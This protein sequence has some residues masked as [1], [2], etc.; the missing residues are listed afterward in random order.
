MNRSGSIEFYILPIFT[1]Y[2]FDSAKNLNIPSIHNE[3]NS[4]NRYK[5][6][7]HKR[8][9]PKKFQMKSEIIYHRNL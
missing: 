2:S 4:E 8:A 3:R 1:E 6:I 5:K 9:F 7:Y